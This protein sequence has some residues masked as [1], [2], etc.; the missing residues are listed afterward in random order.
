MVVE[1]RIAHEV[2]AH[3]PRIRQEQHIV[4]L[5]DLVE[6]GF[7]AGSADADQFLRLLAMFAKLQLGNDI[8]FLRDRRI[9]LVIVETAQ[10]GLD[11]GRITRADRPHSDALD[12]PY[13]RQCRH[14]PLSSRAYRCTGSG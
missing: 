12:L 3:A 4:L 7:E 11:D 14:H 6:Q 13:V 5:G 9:E 2:D 10:P 8:G 1:G